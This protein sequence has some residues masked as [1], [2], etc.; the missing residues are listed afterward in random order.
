M[1]DLVINILQLS[2]AIF[3]G[4]VLFDYWRSRKK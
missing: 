3:V 4:S 2:I 1:M